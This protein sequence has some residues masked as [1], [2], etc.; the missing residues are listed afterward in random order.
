[1][2]RILNTSFIN[3]IEV[4]L[5]NILVFSNLKSTTGLLSFVNFLVISIT[6][7]VW[8]VL[9]FDNI[10]N[11]TNLSIYSSINTLSG[12]L[13]GNGL[14]KKD[15]SSITC[16]SAVRFG[17]TPIASLKLNASL[18]LHYQLH[19]LSLFFGCQVLNQTNLFS[20]TISDCQFGIYVDHLVLTKCK[21]L[22]DA[23]LF[24]A[25]HWTFYCTCP[26]SITILMCLCIM[27]HLKLFLCHRN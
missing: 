9:F 21:D 14:T 3:G 6:G 11:D 17:H 18:Y 13:S 2:P 8:L 7:D 1:M 19:Q 12:S 15:D 23:P 24:C 27:E 5:L 22:S 10:P 25:T 26:W 16:I 20:H 4:F